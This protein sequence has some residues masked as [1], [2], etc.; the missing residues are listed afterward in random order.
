MGLAMVVILLSFVGFPLLNHVARRPQHP[1][2]ARRH[3]QPTEAPGLPCSAQ[4]GGCCAANGC[5]SQHHRGGRGGA[6][7]IYTTLYSYIVYSTACALVRVRV[8]GWMAGGERKR[9]HMLLTAPLL[10]GWVAGYALQ[11]PE[12]D[13]HCMCSPPHLPVPMLAP[14]CVAGSGA[15]GVAPMAVVCSCYPRW[16]SSLRCVVANNSVSVL[17][18]GFATDHAESGWLEARGCALCPGPLPRP[19]ARASVPPLVP[20]STR[21]VHLGV[22][23]VPGHVSS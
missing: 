17:H 18:V 4:L 9:R 3:A 19:A 16:P 15:H 12:R 22:N 23:C 8:H 1:A 2:R 10:H 7:N 20:A 11:R 6:G 13:Q 21:H 5:S 14:V